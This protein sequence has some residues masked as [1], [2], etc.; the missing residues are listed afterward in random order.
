MIMMLLIK[1]DSAIEDAQ[2]FLDYQSDKMTW[3]TFKSKCLERHSKFN[4]GSIN[5]G[6]ADWIEGQKDN[7]LSN[8]SSGSFYTALVDVDD[9]FDD[10]SIT[11][12][13]SK[14]GYEY[15]LGKRYNLRK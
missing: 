11:E 5:E 3:E 10:E 12:E 9:L 15:Y 14:V 4:E 2:D 1:I 6:Y 7:K 13:E 8:Q